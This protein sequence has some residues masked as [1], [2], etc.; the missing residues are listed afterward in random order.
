MDQESAGLEAFAE[1]LSN[2]YKQ[3]LKMGIPDSLAQNLV[4]DYQAIVL[5]IRY[6]ES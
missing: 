1:L 4:A 2:Y 5:G 6:H 3:L